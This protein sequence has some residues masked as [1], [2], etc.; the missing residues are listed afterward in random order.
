[1]SI[2]VIA[3]SYV[4]T[5]GRQL[6]TPLASLNASSLALTDGAVVGNQPS[7]GSSGTGWTARGGGPIYRTGGVNGKP[8]LKQSTAG[9]GLN[10]VVNRATGTT[11]IV[12][13][14][15][16]HSGGR[17][18]SGVTNNWLLGWWT[19]RDQQF[20]AEGWVNNPTNTADSASAWIY[21]GTVDTAADS[22]GIYRN[23][24]LLAAN[25]GGS[26][27][28]NGVSSNGDYSTTPEYSDSD[29][30]ALYVYDHV[31]SAAERAA[32]HSDL[33]DRYGIT[34]ADYTP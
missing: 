20:Y 19:G 34:V 21:T 13:V 14:A 9:A 24:T 3:A 5:T 11:S 26:A 31:L 8:Y 6:P 25:N 12:Y 22:F 4:A 33:S 7:G 16:W 29:L 23:G 30:Y 18:I 15:R 2:G 10:W 32:V 27:G 1:M 17:V 28:P